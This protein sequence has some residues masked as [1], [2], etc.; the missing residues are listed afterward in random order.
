MLGN[1]ELSTAL[2]SLGALLLLAISTISLCRRDTHKSIDP[3]DHLF[4]GHSFVHSVI[5]NMG[6]I[7]SVTYFFGATFIYSAIYASWTLVIAVLM[8]AIAAIM[9]VRV[10]NLAHSTLDMNDCH[11]HR[12]N[13]LLSLLKKRL[14]KGHYKALAY[15]YLLIYFGLLIEELAVSRVLLET[16]FQ[17]QY[18]FTIFSL[19]TIMLVSM[20]YVYVGGFR[21]VLISDYVQGIV[22]LAFIG[23]LFTR[24][25]TAPHASPLSLPDTRTLPEWAAAPSLIVWSFFGISWLSLAIDFYSRLNIEVPDASV[26]HARLRLAG[27]SLLGTLLI[28]IIGSLFS[29]SAAPELASFSDAREYFDKALSIFLSSRS[30]FVIVTFFVGLFSMIFTTI[31]M[32]MLTL[33]QISH[34]APSSLFRRQNLARTMVAATF[35][36]VVLPANAVCAVGI[37][38]GSLLIIIAPVVVREISQSEFF[39]FIPSDSA[40]F[41]VSV[42]LSILLFL[43][44]FKRLESSFEWHFMIP[45]IVLGSTVG[46]MIVSRL[47]RRVTGGTES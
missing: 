13:L 31:D 17:S 33:L 7:F 28:V 18:A 25:S 32:L 21:A 8:F 26:R 20:A 9:I 19:A 16:M 14:A 15:L 35:F 5:S 23:I 45:G 40:Y 10:I 42:A 3:T 11:R 37:F 44:Y 46:G 6:A 29:Y 39:Q 22:L 27:L 24:V 41:L 1:L 36:S 43:T 47:L 34:E 4:H 38:I 2:L 30:T 12:G